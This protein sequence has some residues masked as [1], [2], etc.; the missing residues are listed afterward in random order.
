MPTPTF[1]TGHGRLFIMLLNRWNTKM[2]VDMELKRCPFCG[3]EN[4]FLQD[5]E[6]G[7][8]D[9]NPTSYWV[10]C[11]EITCACEGP[12]RKTKQEA[13]EAWNTRPQK[14]T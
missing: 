12:Y 1:T 13:I 2:G 3:G 10:Q 5:D 14:K 11:E 9:F 4:L 8:A 6:D 7:C